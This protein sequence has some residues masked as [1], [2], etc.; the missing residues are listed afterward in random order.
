M[1]QFHSPRP[2]PRRPSAQS[3]YVDRQQQR[4]SFAI[5]SCHFL[6]IKNPPSLPQ[7]TQMTV[8]LPTTP[9]NRTHSHRMGAMN[10][11]SSYRGAPPR[12]TNNAH[13]LWPNGPICHLLGA[14]CPQQI[15]FNP[16][17]LQPL[18][19]KSVANED[20]PVFED[21]RGERTF[22]FFLALRPSL[23]VRCRAMGFRVPRWKEQLTRF[24]GNLIPKDHFARPSSSSYRLF[25]PGSL[26]TKF[27]KQVSVQITS[28]NKNASLGKIEEEIWVQRGDWGF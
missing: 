11:G 19:R 17:L 14:R 28:I 24:R 10:H 15:I 16:G 5:T 22:C 1:G 9:R 26:A 4:N 21:E 12:L 25:L 6:Y 20:C 13:T 18:C 27:H 8:G 7:K 2:Y 23:P 3:T